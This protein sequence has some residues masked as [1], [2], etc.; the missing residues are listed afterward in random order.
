MFLEDR[1][2]LPVKQSA[3]CSSTFGLKQANETCKNRGT[4]AR[5]GYLMMA[6]KVPGDHIFGGNHN[7]AKP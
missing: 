3:L 6:A 1:S 2:I 4:T 5:D 7:T